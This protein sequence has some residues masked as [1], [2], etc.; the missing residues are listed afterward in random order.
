MLEQRPLSCVGLPCWWM[1]DPLGQR[2][3]CL[4]RMKKGFLCW[5]MNCPWMPWDGQCV[6]HW[7]R[8]PYSRAKENTDLPHFPSPAPST[9]LLASQ[10]TEKWGFHPGPC[11]CFT[12]LFHDGYSLH[13]PNRK[14]GAVEGGRGPTWY[15]R[16]LWSED[17]VS[18]F[19]GL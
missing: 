13:V 10:G 14:H 2:A 9:L 16:E 4:Y 11:S 3:H 15:L 8:S 1:L 5:V 18:Q 7:E 17:K 12:C 19:A 6:S